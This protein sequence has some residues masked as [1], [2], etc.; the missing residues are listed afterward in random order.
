MPFTAH[1]DISKPHF[2]DKTPKTLLRNNAA[3]L[4]EKVLTTVASIT[5][6]NGLNYT[7]SPSPNEND[8]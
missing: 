2:A 7:P 4:T 8:E 5:L 6:T 3:G 1:F